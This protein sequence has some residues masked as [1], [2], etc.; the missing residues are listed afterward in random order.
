M[1]P[2]QRQW[3]LLFLIGPKLKCFCER[4][5]ISL[6][7]LGASKEGIKDLP[8][9]HGDDVNADEEADDQVELRVL[10]HLELQKVSELLRHH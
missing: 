6:Q 4:S 8:D 5:H 9:D 7:L 3:C 1:G 2:V 10:H